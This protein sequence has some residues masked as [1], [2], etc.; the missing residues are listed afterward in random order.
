MEVLRS[1]GRGTARDRIVTLLDEGS[2][3]E[4]DALVAHR[5]TDHGMHQHRIPGDGV[6]CGYGT[7]DGRRVHCF[8]QDFT[9]HGGAVGEMHAAK[10]AKIVDMADRSRTPLVCIW[11]GGG[12]RAHDGITALAGMGEVLDRL[13]GCSGRIPTIS[14]VLGPV[15]G[16]SALAATLSD[17]TIL[18]SDHGQLFLSS[19]L[20]TPRSRMVSSTL[21]GLVVPTSMHHAVASHPWSRTRKQRHVT[22]LR[23]SSRTSRIIMTPSHPIW[24]PPTPTIAP[25]SRSSTLFPTTR[26]APTT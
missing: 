23:W 9:V 16:V 18:G 22:S 6:V 4:I 21:Q 13:V 3:V 15:V 8:S 24:R 17:F 12:Q 19:P 5:I 11:D 14:L 20:E 25:M 2:F 1:S 7:I 10:I 26:I